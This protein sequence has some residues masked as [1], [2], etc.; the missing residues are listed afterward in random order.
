MIAGRNLEVNLRGEI[1]LE[2]EPRRKANE[3]A[4]CI[5]IVARKWLKEE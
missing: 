2:R 4:A 5:P 1:I 3:R